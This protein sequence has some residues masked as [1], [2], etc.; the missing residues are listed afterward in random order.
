MKGM[1][2][3]FT[4]IGMIPTQHKHATH[5]WGLAILS[6]F[7]LNKLSSDSIVTILEFLKTLKVGSPKSSG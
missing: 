4:K 5:P 2:Q 3:I 6:M 1:R 7:S